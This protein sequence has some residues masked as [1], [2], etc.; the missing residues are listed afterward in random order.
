MSE[1]QDIRLV[2]YEVLIEID[3]LAR[4]PNEHLWPLIDRIVNA[5]LGINNE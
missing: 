5:A 1:L 4:I 2:V 3:C